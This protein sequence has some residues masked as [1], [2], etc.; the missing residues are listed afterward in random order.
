MERAMKKIKEL[1]D[2]SVFVDNLE[3]VINSDDYF[4]RY[5]EWVLKQIGVGYLMMALNNHLEIMDKLSDENLDDLIYAVACC[6]NDEPITAAIE[7]SKKYNLS[8]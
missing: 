4:N 1:Y 6:M 8:V 2:K 3:E 7:E 5:D